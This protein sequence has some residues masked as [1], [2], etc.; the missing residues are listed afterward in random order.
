MPH[1]CNFD[2]QWYLMKSHPRFIPGRELSARYFKE[3]VQPI[4]QSS[5]PGLAY[6]AALLGHG[7]EV[8]GFDTPMSRDHNWGPRLDF[9]LPSLQSD[10]LAASI[11]RV[12]GEQIPFEFLGYPT[13]FVEST[14]EPGTLLPAEPAGRP[15]HPYLSILEWGAFLQHQTGRDM[16]DGPWLSDWLLVPEQILRSLAQGAVFHDGLG[17]LIPFQE[18]LRWYPQDVWR[19]LL[20][21]Q[22]ARLGQEE[23]FVG[24][25]GGV[26]DETG[27]QVLA[28]RL[29]RDLMRL[30]LLLEQSYAPYPKWFGTAFSRLACA[31]EMAPLLANLL[32]ATAWQARQDALNR[33]CELAARLQNPLGL[34]PPVPETVTQFYDRPFRVIQGEEIGHILQESIHDPAI[35]ALPFGVGKVDQWVDNTDILSAPERF[36]RLA[37]VYG[38]ADT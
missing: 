15:I 25:T 13:H 17:L 12:L 31:A 2:L 1:G 35:R 8:L 19:Y 30:C 26:G 14:N 29:S 23:P 11:R 3:A 24:R 28:A 36:R 20:A 37:A 21:S 9:F 10:E 22:W 33:A 27:S 6:S 32:N 16:Q 34:C 38:L 18:A 5:F 7:S 4:L